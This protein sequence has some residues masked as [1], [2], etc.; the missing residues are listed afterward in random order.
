MKR[1]CLALGLAAI[2][3]LSGSAVAAPGDWVN[4]D[5][6]HYI[7][8]PKVTPAELRGKV[9]LVDMWAIWCGP[10]IAMLPHTQAIWEEYKNR[11]VIVVGSHVSGG[12]DEA[13]VKEL[14]TNKAFSFPFYLSAKW[15]GNV[16]FDGG[17]PFLYVIN[18]KGEC[19]YGG[20]KPDE[21]KRAIDKALST[22]ST[23]ANL[24]GDESVLVEYK[25]LKGKM[26]LGKSVLPTMKRLKDDIKLAKQNPSSST[27]AKRKVE[28][29]KIAKMIDERKKELLKSIE[30][31]ISDANNEEAIKEID[32]LVGTWPNLKEEWIAKRSELSGKK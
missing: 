17:I 31:N 23:A 5:D 32:L 22:L 10:C 18:G 12:Y 3:T 13:R 19:V 21:I 25:N 27:Y 7:A 28:A 16:G 8:G 26:V 20:R 1:F 4:F 2:L 11:P 24:L 6:E 29:I 30:R 15:E 9:V 14:I